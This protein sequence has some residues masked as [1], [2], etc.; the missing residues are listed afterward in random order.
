VGD[1]ASA[2]R[3]RA[4]GDDAT[5]ILRRRGNGATAAVARP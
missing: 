5:W 1:R 4:I 2:A 3:W